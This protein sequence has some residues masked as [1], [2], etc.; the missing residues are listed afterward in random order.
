MSGRR[1]QTGATLLELLLATAIAVLVATAVSSWTWTMLG[2]Q[3]EAAQVLANATDLGR[4][5]RELT[6]DVTSARTVATSGSD[7]TGGG[8]GSAG[9]TV[10]LSLVASG[11]HPHVIVYTEARVDPGDPSSERSLWR[12]VCGTDG[13][14]VS[15]TELFDGV[16]P[17]SVSASC[18]ASGPA[19]AGPP[20]AQAA[21]R[22]VVLQWTAM[23]RRGP[24]SRPSQLVA[25]RRADLGS[26]GVATSGNR[27]P[28]AQFD[29]D[30]H[31]GFVGQPFTFDATAS[32]DIGG[33]IVAY[34][35]EFPASASPDLASGDVVSHSFDTPGEKTV[36]LK[37]T[38]D[39][40]ESS[41]AA[42]TVRVVNRYPVARIAIS[43]TAGVRG[44]QVFTFDAAASFDPDD[45]ARVLSYRWDLGADLG[46]DRYRSEAVFDYTFPAEAVAGL[47]QIS[48]TVTDDLGDTDTIIRQVRLLDPNEVPF[49]ITLSPE[50]FLAGAPVPTVG[51][52]G[53]N[54]AAFEV[55]FSVASA[56]PLDD[57]EWVLVRTDLPGG[58]PGGG[59]QIATGVGMVWAHTFVPGDGGEYRVLRRTGSGN[60]VGEA[61]Q[62]HLNNAPTA[63][64][65]VPPG[66]GPS[67]RVV[68]LSSAGSTDPDGDQLSFRW[69]LGFFDRWTS[70][71][72]NPTHVFTQPGRYPVSL[73]AVDSFGAEH[74]VSAEVLVDGTP[75][76]P[77]PPAWSGSSV[78]F[79]PVPGAAAY[80]VLLRCDGAPTTPPFVEIPAVV[81]PTYAATNHCSGGVADAAVAVGSSASGAP[82]ISWGPAS[83]FGV[84]P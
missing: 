12:R 77:P 15:A 47:R 30:R 5:G 52:V 36:L 55:R 21:N 33:T 10:R 27:P 56:A 70:T 38:D 43:P 65:G 17:G 66:A 59:T 14:L 11:L 72:A 79:D 46:V 81:A 74:T 73:T 1:G 8:P 45:P 60:Q 23:T 41:A 28:I 57:I 13:S 49:D 71:T 84:R 24:A 42:V 22:R 69:N 6:R 4:V 29:V 40:G 2:Q 62:F 9:A 51:S 63:R 64:I 54:V 26:V 32:E 82:G 68:D 19:V 7:C 18:P 61:V 67:P 25:T 78:T 83:A 16:S 3:E 75:V 53:G 80:R 37:V 35:W 31:V 76:A 50:P 20:C 48:L 44:A 34:D 39:A 58:S